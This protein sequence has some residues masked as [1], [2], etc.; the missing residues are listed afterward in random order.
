MQ[1]QIFGLRHDKACGQNG[2][3]GRNNRRVVFNFV[4]GRFDDL[5]A[6]IGASRLSRLSGR[7]LEE[8]ESRKCLQRAVHADGRPHGDEEHG[9]QFPE[10]AHDQ[11]LF[12]NALYA[13]FNLVLAKTVAM[14][15]CTNARM[16]M[17]P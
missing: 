10:L 7:A 16:H 3:E 8:L 2:E 15:G 4:A 5:A 13:N 1:N 6:V 9:D 17:A 14:F 11:T 12:R